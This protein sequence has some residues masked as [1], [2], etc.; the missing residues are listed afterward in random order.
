MKLCYDTLP[1][2]AKIAAN[3]IS[4]TIIN[5][6]EYKDGYNNIDKLARKGSNPSF[7]L[8]VILCFVN[9][10]SFMMFSANEWL[11]TIEAFNLLDEDIKEELLPFIFGE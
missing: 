7:Q 8:M 2:K 3:K 6:T 1:P 9:K 4:A 10:Y 5:S 11:K